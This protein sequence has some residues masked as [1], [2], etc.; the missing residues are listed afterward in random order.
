M[1]KEIDAV[2]EN[3]V[4]GDRTLNYP[5]VDACYKNLK[6]WDVWNYDFKKLVVYD[7]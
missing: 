5:D 6:W 4:N 3:R 2:F 7:K 1:K